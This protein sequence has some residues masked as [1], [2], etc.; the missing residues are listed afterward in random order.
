MVVEKKSNHRALNLPTCEFD[1]QQID[2]NQDEA[3]KSVCVYSQSEITSNDV[4]KLFKK[5]DQ[6]QPVKGGFKVTFSSSVKAQKAVSQYHGKAGLIVCQDFTPPLLAK[7]HNPD[8]FVIRE[9]P[10]EITIA[11]LWTFINAD[12]IH[13]SHISFLPTSSHDV[14]VLCRDDKGQK[15][16]LAS[17]KTKLGNWPVNIDL[18]FE[19]CARMYRKDVLFV[20]N[21]PEGTTVD[22]LEARFGASDD[23]LI[24]SE[25][26]QIND[27]HR[28]ALVALQSRDMIPIVTSFDHDGLKFSLLKNLK[29]D[30]LVFLSNLHETVYESDILNFLK[31]CGNI[32]KIRL[33]LNQK[34]GRKGASVFFKTPE[35][36]E[37][38]L[39]LDGTELKGLL[40]T[41]ARKA[42]Q[43]NLRLSSTTIYLTNLHRGARPI[44]LCLLFQD[45]GYIESVH[46]PKQEDNVQLR[47]AGFVKFR[48]PAAAERAM[49]KPIGKIKGLRVI[50]HKEDPF[51]VG[52]SK[53]FKKSRGK[54]VTGREF[55]SRPKKM[56]MNNDE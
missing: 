14:L 3:E 40:V 5:C 10:E 12:K 43:P 47:E 38:A 41:V 34:L 23:G 31:K 36:A 53:N 32:M 17:G 15:Q 9:V 56:K 27:T 44:D 16:L 21:L 13:A 50:A 55:R 42:D 18:W 54:R 46:V 6:I 48:D 4:S 1:F 19:F 33:T 30:S 49:S 52:K 29:S 25:F 37:N 22:S 35:E 8:V 7:G 28:F 20:E 2:D 39:K 51:A 45:C 11:E 26:I 24:K